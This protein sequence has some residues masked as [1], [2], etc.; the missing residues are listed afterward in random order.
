MLRSTMCLFLV[1]G[2]GG[3]T[4]RAQAPLPG[5]PAETG[6]GIR[7]GPLVLHPRFELVDAGVDSNVFNDPERP[8]RDFTATF[9]PGLNAVVRLGVARIALR[10]SVEAV[11]FQ[12]FADERSLNRTG[13]VRTE[14]R[15]SR[16]VPYA[17]VSGLV[18]SQRPNNEVDLR[19]RRTS[20]GYGGGAAFLV[21]SRTAAVVSVQH[22]RLAY[23]PDQSFAGADLATQFNHR[24]DSYELGARIALTSL[25]TM[26]LT[27]GQERMR[28]EL[29]PERD[30]DST[31]AGVSFEFDPQAIISGSASIAYRRFDLAGPAL[32]DFRGLVSQV[33]IQYS[34]QDR[35][36]VSVRYV[37]DVDYSVEE[38]QPYYVLTAGT[39]TLTQRIGGPF[40]VQGTVARE[41]RRYRARTGVEIDPGDDS[42]TTNTAAAGVGY[43][44]GETARIG[45]NIEFTSRDAL[46]TGRSY[47]RRRIV[48]SITYG[49]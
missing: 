20:N 31:R 15:L 39:V 41:G 35:T 27:G 4:A 19:A 10:T 34:F 25:T 47:D 12:K 49:F 38:G 11:H 17:T 28:F 16:M 48:S 21:F 32:P 9:R 45:V 13:E 3:A 6:G 5:D 8:E 23:A 36:A 24:R 42:D 14:L 29:S 43:R 44:L 1:L 33:T 37:R 30:T 22:Q 2:F 46:N 26:S 40:D 18:T 7:T